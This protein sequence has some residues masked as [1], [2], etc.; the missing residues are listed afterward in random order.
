MNKY[1]IAWI[2]FFE[3]ELQVRITN[4]VNEEEALK[5]AYLHLT[6]VDYDPMID[7]EDIKVAAIDH[8]GAIGAVE[9][10]NSCFGE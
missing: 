3:N 4:K 6:G 8:D 7:G 2:S 9:I 5:R 10:E 1:A